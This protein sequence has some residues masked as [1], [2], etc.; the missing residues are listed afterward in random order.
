[1]GTPDYARLQALLGADSGESRAAEAHGTLCGLLCAGAGDLPETWISNT[2]ADSAE[3]ELPGEEAA[4]ALAAVYRSTEAAISGDQ[5]AFQPLLPPDDRPLTERA[6]ALAAWCQG[7]LYGLAVRGLRP[8]EELPDEL[9]E[10]LADFSEISRAA[11]TREETEEQGEEAY[12]ELVEYVRVAVQLFFDSCTTP[13]SASG[14][15]PPD[16]SLH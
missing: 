10:I 13:Q 4:E 14:G 11:F 7:F 9:R 16:R 8:V 3:G 5:M 2:L 6:E 15:A 1:M 12:A